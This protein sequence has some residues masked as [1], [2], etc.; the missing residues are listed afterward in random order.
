MLFGATAIL[1]IA[2]L[3]TTLARVSSPL[4]CFWHMGGIRNKS[5]LR[6]LH[7]CGSRV[8]LAT[9]VEE[10]RGQ[11]GLWTELAETCV[12]TPSLERDCELL[13]RG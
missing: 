5:A 7:L 1:S 6:I 3:R 9:S 12:E 4:P 10:S 11:A 2:Q 8:R 13:E